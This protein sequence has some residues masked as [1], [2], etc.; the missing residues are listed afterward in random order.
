MLYDFLKILV[1]HY[2]VI[3]HATDCIMVDQM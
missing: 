3:Y 1:S 2:C